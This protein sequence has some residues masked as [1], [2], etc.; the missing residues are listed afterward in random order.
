[1]RVDSFGEENLDESTCT[2]SSCF[3]SFS[4]A[5]KYSYAVQS[6]LLPIRRG[7][8]TIRTCRK[9]LAFCQLVEIGGGYFRDLASSKICKFEIA[10]ALLTE[11]DTASTTLWLIATTSCP[12]DPFHNCCCD[13]RAPKFLGRRT[14]THGCN[15]CALASLSIGASGALPIFKL[16]LSV[17]FYGLS[18]SHIQT[19]LSFSIQLPI[20][21]FTMMI[22]KKHIHF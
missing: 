2:L 21:A 22:V 1:M 20:S 9:R 12:P 14:Y 7:Q 19:S 16:G 11:S 8:E 5:A 18:G 17:H 4:N 15:P 6:V 10:T 13:R 3:T